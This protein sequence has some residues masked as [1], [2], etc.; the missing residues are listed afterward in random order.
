MCG[1][2]GE[3]RRLA[4]RRQ[5]ARRGFIDL[6][7]CCRDADPGLLL[8]AGVGVD[9]SVV[10]DSFSLEDIITQTQRN[11]R[12]L[13]Q[14][15]G[16]CKASSSTSMRG[17]TPG[18][19]VAAAGFRGRALAYRGKEGPGHPVSRPAGTRLSREED[20][21]HTSA[22]QRKHSGCVGRKHAP[23]SKRGFH[24][25]PQKHGVSQTG[26][27][28]LSGSSPAYAAQGASA[29]E[30]RRAAWSRSKRESGRQGAIVSA[31]EYAA[32]TVV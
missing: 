5:R 24:H 18:K 9:V 15:H 7:G 13:R 16:F 14:Q 31:I 3:K 1:V 2:Y 11:L 26:V 30:R 32:K 27:A 6:A 22:G 17:V 20:R 4:A 21:A 19:G 28:K 29:R 23:V 12:K 10:D 8:S 25:F